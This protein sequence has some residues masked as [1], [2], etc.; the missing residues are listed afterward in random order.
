M[1]SFRDHVKD[2]AFRLLG[3]HAIVRAKL[4]AIERSGL[5]TI[6]NLHRVAP[7]DGSS[8]PPLAPQLFD[9]LLGF[10]KQHFEVVTFGTMAQPTDRPRLILSFDDGYA[11]FFDHA[12]PILER[13]GLRANQNIIPACIERGEPP[14][15]VIM[16][17]FIGR[18]PRPALRS[19]KVEGFP[20]DA[21]RED[22]MALGNRMSSFLKTQTIAVQNRLRE[23]LLPQLAR[24]AEF[25]AT[26]MMSLEQV[27]RAASVH[28]IG[29]HS[30]EHASLGLESDDYLRDDIRRCRAWFDSR[31]GTP[32]SICA[33]PNGSYRL[34]QVDILRAEG[35]AH[36]LLVDEDFTPA[37][38]DL[39]RRFTFDAASLPE[40]RFRATGGW[41]WPTRR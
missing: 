18:A 25:R 2:A 7:E 27:R 10:V 5:V 17:D 34:G 36:I 22:R 41:R 20:F 23:A 4:R 32:L 28:E 29:A 38:G 30:F 31:L 37:N 8:Y 24:V 40:L 19:L 15:N 9:A 12:M 13:H 33:V 26:P 21:D 39:H 3:S 14:L 11:D 16:Q 6:L 1:P 35:I